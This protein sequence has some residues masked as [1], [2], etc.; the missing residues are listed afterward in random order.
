M[1]SFLLLISIFSTSVSLSQ[2][3]TKSHR[4]DRELTFRYDNDVV[5]ITDQ[6]YTSGVDISFARLP[7]KNAFISRVFGS[8]KNDSTKLIWRMDYGHKIF[9]SEKI[10]EP[11]VSKRDRPY[12]G[13]HYAGLFISNFPTANSANIYGLRIGLVGRVSG[14]GNFQTWWHDKAGITAPLGWNE[15][16]ANEFVTNFSYTRLQALKVL[17]PLDFISE[18][19][20]IFGNGNTSASQQLLMRLGQ[21]NPINNS[22]YAGSRL[23]NKVPDLGSIDLKQE[24][25][26]FFYA[27]KAEY[28]NHNI[29]IEGSRFNEN[30]PHVEEIE[31]YLI[32]HSWGGIYSNYYTTFKIIF[33]R[34]SSEVVGGRIHRY[35]SIELG[36]RF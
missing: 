21:L 25:A 23:S 20:I 31:N 2:E 10:R 35:V 16:I 14:I 34:L 1:K 12:A 28:V 19:K 30:S 18:S 24:E 22:G 9:T 15:Q 5:F 17:K 32:Q 4:H 6:Y 27:L 3:V 26:F 8:N 13:W 7:R 11:D 33:Y 36:L 29:F